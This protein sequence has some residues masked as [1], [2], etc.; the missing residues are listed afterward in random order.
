MTG[1]QRR[2][3][4]LF[5]TR[6]VVL[7]AGSVAVIAVAIGVGLVIVGFILRPLVMAPVLIVVGAAGVAWDHARK[8]M[9]DPIV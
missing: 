6:W 5:L 9:K 7:V 8:E 4:R 3:L 2:F 1:R